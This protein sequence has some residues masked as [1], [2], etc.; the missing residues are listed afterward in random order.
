MEIDMK[1]AKIARKT[2]A[3]KL[4]ESR[5]AGFY[6]GLKEGAAVARRELLPPIDIR[7]MLRDFV[8]IVESWPIEGDALVSVVATDL[9]TC[10]HATAPARVLQN[11]AK[12]L[13][14]L[15]G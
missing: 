7:P 12:E 11:A 6:E 4:I 8:R 1:K 13:K 9:R 3:E 5:R 2:L 10:S 15:L 14:K